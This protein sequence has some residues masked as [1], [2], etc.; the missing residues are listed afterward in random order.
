MNIIETT[1]ANVSIELKYI[2]F[3]ITL[4]RIALFRTVSNKIISVV[5]TKHFSG[6]GIFPASRAVT[7]AKLARLASF[8]AKAECKPILYCSNAA[9]LSEVYEAIFLKDSAIIICL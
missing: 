2:G 5:A 3:P 9:I 8:A 7:L 1:H 4:L 6:L